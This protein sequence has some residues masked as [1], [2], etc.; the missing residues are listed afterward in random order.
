V[1]A[2][3]I[4]MLMT[5]LIEAKS[6]P[7]SSKSP[8]PPYFLPSNLCGI[9]HYFACNKSNFLSNRHISIDGVMCLN[10]SSPG[11]CKNVFKPFDQR[12]DTTK[13]F[14]YF[15]LS[16]FLFFLN[17]CFYKINLFPFFVNSYFVSF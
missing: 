11:S 17:S 5:S 16:F 1:D 6:T 14:F 13:V 12:L 9:V 15:L 4:T 8:A 7:S 10:E 2:K 3:I